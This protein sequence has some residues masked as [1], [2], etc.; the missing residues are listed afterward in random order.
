MTPSLEVLKEVLKKLLNKGNYRTLERLLEKTHPGDIAAVFRY[1]DRRERLK[2][3]EILVEKDIKKA[4]DVLYDIDEDIQIE[5]LRSLDTKDAV[6]VLTNFSA[7]E[8]AEIIDKLP[9]NLQREVLSSL[10]E[11]EREEIEKYLRQEDSIAPLISDEFISVREDITVQEAL[12]YIKNLPED[13]DV[14]YIYVVDDKNRIVG[15]VSL[16][17][18]LAS[19]PNALLKDV[20]NRDVIS[21]RDDSTKEDA[22]EI[23]RRYDLLSL[24][25][26]DEEDR[27]IG[28]I[29]IDDILDVI[30]E[31]TTEEVLKLAGATEEEIFF[32]DN[33]IKV[34]KLRLPWFLVAIVGELIT[35][36]I[37]SRFEFTIRQFLPIIFFIPLVAALSGNI[38][39]QSAIIVARG[40]ITER[41][42]ENIKDF[43]YVLFREIKVA[44]IIAIF[45]AVIVGIVSSI[46]LS[47]HILG[48]VVGIALFFNIILASFSGSLLPFVF[49]R[50]DFDP[51]LAT[52]PLILT[53]NDIFGILIYL[54]V[55]TTFIHHLI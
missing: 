15:V 45:S 29:S 43:L 55:A 42:S 2:T 19:P 3:F 12:E 10:K 22:I 37:I 30:R 49:Y 51:N 23:M 48:A 41:I 33:I 20:M 26:V 25:V 6:R 28:I 16:K 24:P 44:V 1:L 27:I 13:F 8:I 35:A 54:S 9:E 4:S 40:I 11:E 34:A 5:I 46:W 14:I 32:T 31:K 52:N 39:S 7:G 21:I 38:S 53:L 17:E 36:F 18:L 47:N 50:L